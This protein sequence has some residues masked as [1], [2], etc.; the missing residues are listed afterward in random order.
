[1]LKRTAAGLWIFVSVPGPWM[2]LGC[3]GVPCSYRESIPYPLPPIKSPIRCGLHVFNLAASSS[4]QVI[5][6]TKWSCTAVGSQE[7]VLPQKSKET[8]SIWIKSCQLF[9][10][11]VVLLVPVLRPYQS[12]QPHYRVIHH[13]LTGD[14]SWIFLFVWPTLSQSLCDDPISLWWTQADAVV[15]RGGSAR[16]SLSSLLWLLHYRSFRTRSQP[17]WLRLKMRIIRKGV[18]KKSS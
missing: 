9:F 4:D 5:E 13:Q 6:R 15:T 12:N 16:M 2:Q 17:W 18:W 14:E 10:L 7:P 1:M 3:R 8:V 11:W